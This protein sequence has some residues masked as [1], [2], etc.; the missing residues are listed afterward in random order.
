[1]DGVLRILT[2]AVEE[3]L[4]K[5][6]VTYTFPASSVPNNKR[7]FEEKMARYCAVFLHSS[8]LTATGS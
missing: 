6:G 2:A 8:P 4:A 5:I 7:A 3:H 1:M